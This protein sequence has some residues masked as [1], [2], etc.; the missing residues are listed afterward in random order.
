MK[1]VLTALFVLS[2]MNLVSAQMHGGGDPSDFDSIS[3][4]GTAIVIEA[5]SGHNIYYLDEDGDGTGDYLL[6][7]GPYWYE[8]DS[9]NAVRPA[10]GDAISVFGALRDGFGMMSL[11]KIIV[12]EINGEFWR[13][14]FFEDWN[15]MGGGCHSGGGWTGDSLYTVELSGIALVDTTFYMNKYYL[16]ANN[17]GEPDYLLNFGPFWYEPES[18]ATRPANGDEIDI[19]GGKLDSTMLQLPMIIVYEING[20]VWRDSS[21]FG[22]NFGGGWITGDM[23]GSHTFHTPF[24]DNDNMTVH[25]GWN[26][27]GGHMGGWNEYPDSLFCQMYEVA[28]E[29]ISGGE[30]MNIFAGYVINYYKSDGGAWMGNMMGDHS[31]FANDVDYS[32]HYS[33]LQLSVYS[34]DENNIQVKYY[35]AQTNEWIPVNAAINKDAN[36]VSFSSSDVAGVVAISA[37]KLTD[38]QVSEIAPAKFSLS[39]NYPNPFNPSTVIEFTL[40]ADAQVTLSVYN[41]IGEKVA[42]LVNGYKTAGAYKVN[43]DAST[44]AGGL[45]SGIYFYELK[46]GGFSQVRK[47]NLIK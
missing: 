34:A 39:Q 33:D 10:N 36:T 8:P 44:A 9:S 15:G 18:G 24:D 22:P 14:P 16:D 4:S 17:D 11:Q 6:N 31:G 7:F 40:Q 13:D 19:V 45:T 28:P 27:G 32:L 46:A 29:N 12:F 47:M 43:F 25:A 42:E 2:L 30:G 20:L 41:V 1:K 23:Q 37:P 5:M 26:H 21:S 3:V 38:A 35:N